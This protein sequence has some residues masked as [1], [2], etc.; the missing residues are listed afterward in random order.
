LTVLKALEYDPDQEF[1]R[2]LL[3]EIRAS[4]R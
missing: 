1:A 3:S 2:K 4:R